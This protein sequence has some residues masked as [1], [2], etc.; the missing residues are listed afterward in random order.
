MFAILS[1][2]VFQAKTEAQTVIS[3]PPLMPLQD[4]LAP[5]M[6]VPDAESDL[7]SEQDDA[8][9]H[10]PLFIND[11]VESQIEFFTTRGRSIFQSWLDR[12][13]RYLP[14]MKEIFRE[15]NLPEDLVY[16]AMI[17]SGFNPQA[18][19]QKNAVGPWQFMKATARE[20]GLSTNRWVD[21]RKDP[22]KSTHAAAAHFKDL[23][24][25]FGS[26]LM[27]LASY[28]AGMGR[29]Q[30]AILKAKSDDFWEL[31]GTRFMHAE[32]QEYVPRYLAAL[33]IARDPVAYGFSEPGGKPLEYDEII[34]EKSTDLRTIAQY[35]G[36]S[37]KEIRELNPELLQHRTPQA[38]YVL[39]IPAGTREACEQ[40]FVMAPAAE[41][42]SR[43]AQTRVRIGGHLFTKMAAASDTLAGQVMPPANTALF[44]AKLGFAD[45]SLNR[46]PFLKN[47]ESYTR[48]Q[49]V[50]R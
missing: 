19:S 29:M 35:A 39:R 21:E 43:P 11:S 33:I 27:A 23:Y 46:A 5:L 31:R 30:G 7:Q 8:S 50:L 26:W 25:M 44:G 18:V 38:S 12:S 3:P 37:Y 17:E 32:T 1:L 41:K 36:S 15:Y 42:K 2:I 10:I 20:Y 22:V 24:N 9:F 49:K 45:P 28:N 34:V 4:R 48:N 13:A 47:P 14:L 6:D 16:V 40:R